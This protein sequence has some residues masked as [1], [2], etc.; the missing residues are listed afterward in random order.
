MKRN[1]PNQLSLFDIVI[2]H[3][4]EP[5]TPPPIVETIAEQKEQIK[6]GTLCRLG[7]VFWLRNG[8]TH[9]SPKFTP[10]LLLS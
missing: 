8:T 1:N 4:Q 3:P 9:S 6:N 2:K 7:I 5:T 10:E